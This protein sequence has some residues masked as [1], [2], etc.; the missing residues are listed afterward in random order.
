MT[1]C[2]PL[3]TTATSRSHQITLTKMSSTTNP[4]D[5]CP[6][7]ACFTET[8]FSGHER[9]PRVSKLLRCNDPPSDGELSDFQSTVRSGPG[10]LADLDQKIVHAKEHLTTLIHERSVLEAKIDDARTLS[11]PIRRLS[12]DVL[13]AIALETIPSSHEVMN[14]T[15]QRFDSCNSLDSRESPWTLAQV[16]HRWRSTIVNAP[17]V[18]SS[19]SLVIKHDDKPTIV[20]RQMFMTGLRLE[21]SKSFPLTVSLS[22]SPDADISNH[23]LLF[24]ISTRCSLI[25]NLRIGASLISYPV[26]SWW[27]G[28]FDQLYKLSLTSPPLP[29][30]GQ[31][32]SGGVESAIDVFEYAP[33][34]KT[35]G[36]W[37][38]DGLHFSFRFPWTRITH[39]G[40]QIF[41][42]Q[43]IDILRQLNNLNH[44]HIAYGK[45]VFAVPA[46]HRA[47]SLPDLTLLTLTYRYRRPTPSLPLHPENDQIFSLLSIPNLT[48]L[49]LI[50]R[51]G[52]SVSPAIPAS[53][54]ITTLKLEFSDEGDDYQALTILFQSLTNLRHLTI[55]SP[56]DIPTFIIVL[57]LVPLLHLR[58][59][60]FRQLTITCEYAMFVQMIRARR[61]GND[62][63]IDQLESVYLRSPL[64]LS[65]P[66]TSMWQDLIDEGLKVVYG[67]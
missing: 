33:K 37:I 16:S 45:G 61:K 43:D 57:M 2:N 40:I 53:N 34:L 63:S 26:F 14:S 32:S 52:F 38:S 46:D 19:M 48:D 5:A 11:S 36:L 25:R 66:Y 60:D 13:R 50:Y 67:K 49:S 30:R 10:H 62:L 41:D 56:Y 7:C 29:N 58:T 17:E 4:P 31:L 3:S 22:S 1:S 20:V 18:W 64:T 8:T 65:D 59:L 42:Q 51:R 9:S 39:L 12:S 35:V 23:P 21:R 54:T 27:R 6:T 55:S 47:I 15:L 28:R 44:L 24:L